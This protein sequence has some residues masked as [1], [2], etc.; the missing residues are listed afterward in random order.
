MAC[1]QGLVTLTVADETTGGLCVIPGSH[2]DHTAFCKRFK[3]HMATGDYIPVKKG[4]VILN[5][6]GVLLE[7]KPGDLLLWDSRTVH[8]N[9]R[10]LTYDKFIKEQTLSI[11]DNTSNVANGSDTQSE[12]N[13]T[14]SDT[15]DTQ[16]DTN[17]GTKSNSNCDSDKSGDKPP[18]LTLLRQVAYVCMTP[19]EWADK[20]T[21]AKRRAAFIENTS[22][23]HWPH[24]FYGGGIR[25]VD[26]PGGK[27]NDPNVRCVNEYGAISGEQRKLIGLPEN[28]ETTCAIA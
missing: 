15:N 1:V 7:A 12:T 26:L 18:P 9:T 16:S 2:K 6:G 21:I 4:D 11:S 22:T 23:S 25:G 3:Y 14:Q 10:A 17:G 20:E 28:P 24:E 19:S 13:G 27:P 8:C 5:K